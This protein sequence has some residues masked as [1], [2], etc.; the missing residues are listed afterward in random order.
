MGL[1]HWLKVDVDVEGGRRGMS[2]ANTD[3]YRRP[4]ALVP[5]SG[6]SQVFGRRGVAGVEVELPARCKQV[7]IRPSMTVADGSGRL[8]ALL[9]LN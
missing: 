1:K 2:A 4:L 7:V 8:L 3:A 5:A 9:D 6:T